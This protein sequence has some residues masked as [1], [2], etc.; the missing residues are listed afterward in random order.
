MNL[1]SIMD[2]SSVK[3]YAVLDDASFLLLV[4]EPRSQMNFITQLVDNGRLQLMLLM[5]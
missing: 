2:H 3:G 4:K 5:P 1:L